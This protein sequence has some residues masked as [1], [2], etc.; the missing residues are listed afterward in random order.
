MYLSPTDFVAENV[1]VFVKYIVNNRPK[2]CLGY[3]D[4][5]IEYGVQ[6]GHHYV[7]VD[8]LYEDEENAITETLWDYDYESDT[9]D[10]WR[11]TNEYKPLVENVLDTLEDRIIQEELDDEHDEVGFD[12]ESDNEEEQIDEET[13]DDT[14]DEDYTDDFETDDDGDD[15]DDGEDE[16]EEDYEEPTQIVYIRR[17]PS[18]LNQ[19]FA[20]LF[21]FSPLIATMGVIYNARDDIARYL[22]VQYC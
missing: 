17:R 13:E 2:W 20:T 3:V 11:F 5:V 19:V 4:K 16:E 12:T 18:F 7:D 1:S 22:R 9:E 10:A 8:V 15:G 14:D 6:D 21:V